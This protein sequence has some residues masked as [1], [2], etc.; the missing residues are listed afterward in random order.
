VT[1]FV[2]SRSSEQRATTTGITAELAEGGASLRLQ[3]EIGATGDVAAGAGAD[4]VATD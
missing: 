4:A 3:A 2:P 1:L